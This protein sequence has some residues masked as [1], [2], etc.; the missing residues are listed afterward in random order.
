MASL[1]YGVTRFSSV[2]TSKQESPPTATPTPW[3]QKFHSILFMN[4]NGSLQI[5]AS[6]IRYGWPKGRKFNIIPNQLGKLLYDLEWN[7]GTSFFHTF[8]S[9][10]ECRNA[11]LEVGILL[12]NW[13]EGANYLCQRYIDGFLCNVWEKVDFLSYYEDVA[14]KGSHSLGVLHRKSC[15][16]DDARGGRGACG[17]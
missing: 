14:I 17:L 3:P 10:R 13:L 8:H 6:L 5:M 9:S 4:Y 1:I 11:Q 2:S 15:S 12:P 7:N 16:C